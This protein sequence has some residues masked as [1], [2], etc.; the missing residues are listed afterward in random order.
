MAIQC[1]QLSNI[2]STLCRIWPFPGSLSICKQHNISN[3]TKL[4]RSI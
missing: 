2:K 3:T 1:D 4:Y